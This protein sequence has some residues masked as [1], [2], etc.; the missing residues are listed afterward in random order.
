MQLGEDE[1]HLW[2][3]VPG[4]VTDG[5]LLAH[6]GRLLSPDEA[7][8]RG[9]FRFEE[10]RHLYLISHALVRSVL[11]RYAPVA[12][13]LWRF[14]AGPHGKP[15]IQGPAGAPPLRFNL[16]HTHGLAAVAVTRHCAVGADVE[17]VDRPV[18]PGLAR[19]ALA[20]PER[21]QLEGAA[22]DAW[23]ETF[24]S[25]WTL[26]EAYLKACGLGLSHSLQEFGF[27][28]TPGRPPRIQFSGPVRDD[29]DHWQFWQDRT[30]PR[31]CGAVAVRRE[32]RPAL[33]L[34]VFQ[35]DLAA[36]AGDAP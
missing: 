14:T 15:E 16:S 4:R 1:V 18:E 22:G 26:K 24:F 9:R 23:A 17:H 21:G 10:D 31:H 25:F 8:R 11:S 29:P 5:G 34:A 12:P 32:G 30:H 13:A 6:C 35:A 33:S 28:L 2:Y 3:A 19:V 36:W 20:E 27:H 7:A